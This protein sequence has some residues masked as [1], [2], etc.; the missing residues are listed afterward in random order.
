MQCQRCQSRTAIERDGAPLTL[1]LFG[2]IEGCF[3]PECVLEIQTPYNDALR[4]DIAE[5]APGLSAEALAAVPDQMLKFTLC[6]PIPRV[7]S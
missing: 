5:R 4:A 2:D 1:R 3:C 6:L 7:A